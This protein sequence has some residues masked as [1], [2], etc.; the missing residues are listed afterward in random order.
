MKMTENRFREIIGAYGASESRWPEGERQSARAFR[1]ENPSLVAQICE[2]HLQLDSVL[3]S[4]AKPATDDRLLMARILK[5]AQALPQ[6]GAPANDSPPAPRRRMAVP[7]W[8]SLAATLI[9][10]T[11]MGFGI[12]QAAASS[13]G[14]AQAEALLEANSGAQYSYD[15]LEETP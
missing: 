2:G 5:Q 3:G 15:W 13:S 12:G 8:K 14:A 11:G 7:P 6:Q 10:S 1:D 9:L 4:A